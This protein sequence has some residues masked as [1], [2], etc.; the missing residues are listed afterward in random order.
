MV[1][2]SNPAGPTKSK[3]DKGFS[4]FPTS[5]SAPNSGS[6]SG[7]QG[8]SDAISAFVLSRQV[9]NRSSRTVE[10]YEANLGFQ[11]DNGASTLA[12]CDA[13]TIQ[14]HI[15]ALQNSGLRP[16]STPVQTVQVRSNSPPNL[17]NFRASRRHSM[18][19]VF[20]LL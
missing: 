11:R 4:D 19:I 6:H 20:Q 15:T 18:P 1:A 7:A 9:G 17:A 16:I 14:R 10:M 12:D 5:D 2:G 3:Q 13:L 8:L